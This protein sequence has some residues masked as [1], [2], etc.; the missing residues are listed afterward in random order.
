MEQFGLDSPPLN[1]FLFIST[2]KYYF[3]NWDGTNRIFFH[4]IRRFSILFLAGLLSLF[5]RLAK[6]ASDEDHTDVR[7]STQLQKMSTLV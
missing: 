3:K 4:G 2:K 1:I 5:A 7:I 6:K